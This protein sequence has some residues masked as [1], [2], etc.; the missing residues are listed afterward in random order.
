MA[1]WLINI[2]AFGLWFWDLDQSGAVQRAA[3]TDRPPALLFPDM[4]NPKGV[5]TGWHPVLQDY[6]QMS[7][8]GCGRS[9]GQA[10]VVRPAASVPD[11]RTPRW[12]QSVQQVNDAGVV[13]RTTHK[14]VA[15]LS[16]IGPP[17]QARSDMGGA[18]ARPTES[19]RAAAHDFRRKCRSAT[20]RRP[21]LP[22]MTT[23][24]PISDTY[25]L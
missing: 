16:R 3:D 22:R 8:G 13:G 19:S 5:R 7:R 17:S 10:A 1:I 20:A 9:S 2:L 15:S 4:G 23:S 21:P 18:S 6:L 24:A 25:R 14:L 12:Q 11:H